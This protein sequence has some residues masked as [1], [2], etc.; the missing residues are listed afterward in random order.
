MQVNT[1]SL[2]SVSVRYFGIADNELTGTLPAYLSDSTLPVISQV[3]I[4]L[5]VSQP[6]PGLILSHWFLSRQMMP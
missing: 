1:S 2:L 3:S 4:E 5:Q 6:R